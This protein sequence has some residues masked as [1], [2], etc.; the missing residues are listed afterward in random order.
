MNPEIVQL[1][2]QVVILVS[3][4]APTVLAEIEGIKKQEGKSADEI[5]A[6]AGIKFDA[7]DVKA[8]QILA[9]LMEQPPSAPE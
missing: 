3:K 2:L 5:F 8:V 7:N 1:L 9:E 6:E 4:L